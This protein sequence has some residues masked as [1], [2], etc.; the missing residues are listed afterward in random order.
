MAT[1]TN[2]GFRIPVSTDLVRNGATAI[3]NLGSDVD[4]ILGAWQTYTPTISTDGGTTNWTLG[5]GTIIGRYQRVSDKVH[6]EIKFSVG[7][8]VKGDGGIQFSLPVANN[9]YVSPKWVNGIFWDDAPGNYYPT[10]V[11]IQSNFAKPY[12]SNGTTLTQFAQGTPVTI[13]SND[14]WTITGSYTV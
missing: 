10:Q 9:S 3:S 1:T 13:T 11:R 14:Y 4:A 12:L 6:F 2:N 7:N 5:T 8:G